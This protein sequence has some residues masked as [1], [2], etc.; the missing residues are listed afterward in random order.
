MSDG[1]RHLDPDR[2]GAREVILEAALHL[3]AEHGY[4]GIS[5]TRI[6]QPVGIRRPS[7]LHHFPNKEALYRE[8]FEASV[9]D[10]FRRVEGAV[11]E[12]VDGWE[13]ADR[14]LVAGF[15]FFE[16]SPDF[17]RLVRREALDGGTILGLEP[18]R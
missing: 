11:E 10:W 16:A 18:R 7:L 2:P 5:P 14:V 13:Q 6:A 8:V 1:S 3:F 4:E 15:Q 12:P 17:V 9:V